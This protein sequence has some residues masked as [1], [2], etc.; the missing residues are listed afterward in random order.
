MAGGQV[1]LI[2]LTKRFDE[3]VAVDGINAMIEGGEFFSLLGPSGCGKTT[4]LR[5]IAGFE[6]PTS[7]EIVLD[8]SD[9]S[10]VPPH[11]RNVHTVFQNYALFPHLN[12]FDNIAFGLRRRKVARDEVRRRV[13]ESLELVEL[14]ELGSRQ[15]RQLSGG[16]QQRVALARALVLRPAVLLLDEPLGALDAKIR[17]QLRIELKALQEEVGITFVFV[18]HDQE[19]AL[20]MSDRVAVMNEGRI[21]QIG[22]PEAVYEDPA[23]VFVADFL[24]VSNMMDGEPVGWGS[25]E[26]TIKIGEATLRARC[27]DVAARGPVRVV[28]RPERLELLAH[29]SERDNCLVGM[30][31][32]TVY[33]GASRQVIVRL[34]IGAVIQVSVANT[35]SDEG[36]SQG[37]PVCVHVPEDA[38]RVLASPGGTSPAGHANADSSAALAA[39]ASS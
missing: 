38:L 27:G 5:M 8:G 32:R 25:G 20:S 33:V 13:H 31:E 28:A 30:V 18:T 4:T 36:H 3:H 11:E 19:E 17:K 34:P 2:G 6:R 15:P 35:G 7:G 29:G 1:Q 16:Q 21:E 12:V 26:C 10:S 37:T 39:G 14:G 23:S 9:V 22:D 24:G